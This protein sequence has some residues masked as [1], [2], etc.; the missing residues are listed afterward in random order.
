MEGKKRAAAIAALCMVLLLMQARPSHQQFSDYACECIRQCYPA[1][2]DSTPPWLC[3][4]KCAGSCHN[5]DRKD[6]L[7]A[8]RIACLTS[9]VCGLSTPPVGDVDPCT[10]ECD[11]LWGGHGHA[12]EP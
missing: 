9:P 2:R 4:I 10:R 8:C 3:K 7:T 12:K 11:K 5:G 6:A 1:C